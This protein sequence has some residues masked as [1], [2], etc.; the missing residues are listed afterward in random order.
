MLVLDGI[1]V[2]LRPLT[3]KEVMPKTISA[4]SVEYTRIHEPLLHDGCPLCSQPLLH[5]VSCLFA[6]FL[7][8]RLVSCVANMYYKLLV[9]FATTLSFVMFVSLPMSPFLT[10]LGFF[11]LLLLHELALLASTVA[12]TLFCCCGC[13]PAFFAATMTVHPG[14][15]VQNTSGPGGGRDVTHNKDIFSFGPAM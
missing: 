8:R 10:L 3:K 4:L 9:F 2:K 15:S 14:C 6:A 7:C 11:Y 12:P 5:Q 13:P 1:V